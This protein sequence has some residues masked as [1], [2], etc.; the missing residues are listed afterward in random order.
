MRTGRLSAVM[1]V[2]MAV[3]GVTA[4]AE[5]P[6]RDVRVWSDAEKKTHNPEAMAQLA[7][8]LADRDPKTSELMARNGVLN[9]PNQRGFHLVLGVL[10]E[11]KGEIAEAYWEYSYEML[12][13]GPGSETGEIAAEYTAK[14][15]DGK[16]GADRAEVMDTISAL[17]KFAN[18]DGKAAADTLTRV[19]AKRGERVPLLVYLAGAK[20]VAGDHPG[21][22]ATYRRA[23]QLAPS[24]APV[25]IELSQSLQ[26]SGDQAGAKAALD[27]ARKVDPKSWR[28][29][30]R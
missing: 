20:D 10:H 23:L 11:R 27:Q 8:V 18:N 25:W 24:L 7:S 28:F 21:A 14:L 26:R 22:Q 9:F 2:V 4:R 17:Q 29:A 15:L 12:L 1:F 30:A 6:I 5:E 3:V 16:A 13:E 19:M